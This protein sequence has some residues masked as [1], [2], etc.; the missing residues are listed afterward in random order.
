MIGIALLEKDGTNTF[1]EFKSRIEEILWLQQKHHDLIDNNKDNPQI[2]QTSLAELHKL[3]I[4]LANYFDVA[5]EIINGITISTTSENTG[6]VSQQDTRS[7]LPKS[8][9]RINYYDALLSDAKNIPFWIESSEDSDNNCHDKL[10]KECLTD[11]GNSTCCFW[12]LLG[13]PVKHNKEK[14]LF[15][16]EQII[17]AAL[18]YFLKIRIKKFRGGGMTELLLRYPAWLALSSNQLGIE[19]PLSL[20]VSPRSY[21]MTIS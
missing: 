14:P 6:Q 20:Q 11:R 19:M 5:P 13:R 8:I 15:D 4:T 17:L 7:S 1:H 9:Q 12:D 3:N 10:R 16:Y 2:Q 18:E 21:L